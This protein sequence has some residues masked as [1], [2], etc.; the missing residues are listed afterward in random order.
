MIAKAL[1][2]HMIPSLKPTDDIS[3]SKLMMDELRLSELPVV[4]KDHFLGMITDQMLFDDAL[5]FSDVGHYPLSGT[6]AKTDQNTHYFDILK[7]SFAEECPLVAVEDEKEKYLGVVTTTRIV[8]EFATSVAI[9]ASG[10]LLVLRLGIL[11]YSL[12]DISRIIEVNDAKVL[13]AHL[14][15][16]PTDSTK[17][18]VT[19]KLN[20]ENVSRIVASL[21]HHGF[22]V[23]NAFNAV[24]LESN[25]KERLD[26][27]MKYLKI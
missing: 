23:E 17:I 1:I 21:S 11:D 14:S 15:N 6:S 9:S 19:L 16:D 24:S 10:A 2:D 5:Q 22:T 26:I 12:S 7:I 4:D 20:T 27:F 18:L 3:T 8:E 13:S 25:D